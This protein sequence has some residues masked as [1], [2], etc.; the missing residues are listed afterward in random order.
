MPEIL[1]PSH[2]SS[3]RQPCGCFEGAWRS[4]AE[5]S[6]PWVG[7]PARGPGTICPHKWGPEMGVPPL[8]GHDARGGIGSGCV[9]IAF[10]TSIRSLNFSESMENLGISDE[11]L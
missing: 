10:R 9:F 5:S 7:A 11:L 6:R 2:T 4:R 1:P 3:E 8:V